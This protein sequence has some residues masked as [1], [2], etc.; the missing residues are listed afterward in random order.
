[1]T[2]W[3][4]SRIFRGSA[5][6]NPLSRFYRALVLKMNRRKYRAPSPADD[7]TG[8]ARKC[9]SRPASD[10]NATCNFAFSCYV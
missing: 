3:D 7:H 1:M 9:K 2:Y 4:A 6:T 10:F 8:R 5:M